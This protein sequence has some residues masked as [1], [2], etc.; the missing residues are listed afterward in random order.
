MK[1]LKD[2]QFVIVDQAQMR[3][4][5]RK[6]PPVVVEDKTPKKFGWF[7]AEDKKEDET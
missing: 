6:K 2:R 5:R 3:S 4:K 1:I 7:M